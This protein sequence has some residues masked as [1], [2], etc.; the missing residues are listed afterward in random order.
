M[1]KYSKL[2]LLLFANA[3][4]VWCNN[5]ATRRLLNHQ[6]TCTGASR[7]PGH[8]DESGYLSRAV[9]PEIWASAC[10]EAALQ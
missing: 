1:D 7:D 10:L 2:D 4:P 5:L 3:E 6:S 9:C 8:G